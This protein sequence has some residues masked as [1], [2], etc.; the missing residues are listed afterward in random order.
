MKGIT[1]FKLVWKKLIN[2]VGLKQT[3]IAVLYWMKDVTSL[4]ENIATS[5]NAMH[6][7]VV[8]FKIGLFDPNLW[9]TKL[10]REK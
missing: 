8:M 4:I 6:D 3:W 7:K 5:L 2:S 10:S 1:G 9:F